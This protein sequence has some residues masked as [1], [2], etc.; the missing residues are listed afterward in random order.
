LFRH[1]FV[2]LAREDHPVVKRKRTKEQFQTLPHAAIQTEG[3]SHEIAEQYFKTE[4]IK[5]E[6]LRSRRFSLHSNGGGI[7]RCHRYRASGVAEMFASLTQVQI[8]EPPYPLPSYARMQHWCRCQHTDPANIWLRKIVFE[9]LAIVNDRI[10]CDNLGCGFA[11][12]SSSEPLRL[13]VMHPLD[14]VALSR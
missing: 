2:C 11:A 14:I 12:A 13:R 6:S 7:Q 1:R 5:S 3:R 8:L 4:G 9:L 10:P